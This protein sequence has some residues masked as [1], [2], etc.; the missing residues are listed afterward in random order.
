MKHITLMLFLGHISPS[1]AETMN[2]NFVDIN[3][4][5]GSNT[6]FEISRKMISRDDLSTQTEDKSSNEQN[7]KLIAQMESK[8]PDDVS[9]YTSGHYGKERNQGSTT[10]YSQS[11][12]GEGSDPIHGS[13]GPPKCD[14]N[15]MNAEQ[16]LENKMRNAKPLTYTD[17]SDVKQ[18]ENSIK[19]AETSTGS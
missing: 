13:L 2:S 1:K 6:W 15:D 12:Q 11:E 18:N 16:K 3:D 4:Q 19:W 10:T 5:E 17:D 7:K 8:K 14:D 9:Q